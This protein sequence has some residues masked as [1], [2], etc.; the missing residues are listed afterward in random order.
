MGFSVG[1]RYSADNLSNRLKRLATLYSASTLDRERRNEL[2]E[3]QQHSNGA[4]RE[5]AAANR[6]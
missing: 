3:T 1:S 5:A 6:A 4:A 2:A